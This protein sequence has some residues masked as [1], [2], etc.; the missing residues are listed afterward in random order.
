MTN[1]D[2]IKRLLIIQI[3]LAKDYNS[4]PWDDFTRKKVATAID[5]LMS[6]I[7][8]IDSPE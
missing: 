6:L 2:I 3:S 4:L 1:L 8:D 7:S 5:Q